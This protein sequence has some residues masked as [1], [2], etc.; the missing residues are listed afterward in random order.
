MPIAASL[1]PFAAVGAVWLGM[2]GGG[3]PDWVDLKSDLSPRLKHRGISH[4]FFIGA[5]FTLGLHMVLNVAVAEFDWFRLS[6]SEI[7]GLSLAFAVGFL[8]HILADACT[9]AGVRPF[10]PLGSSRL[11]LLPKPLRGKSNGA[12]D[13]IARY[14][15][16]SLVLLSFWR[17]LQPY[18]A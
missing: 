10:L 13:T 15:A 7:T 11:W 4:S 14:I 2:V 1:S 16:I 12:I 5:V 9:H 18:L 8:S 6:A 3:Y 17:V